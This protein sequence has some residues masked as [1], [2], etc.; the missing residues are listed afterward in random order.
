MF[1]QNEETKQDYK[2]IEKSVDKLCLQQS[3]L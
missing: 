3:S 2:E 1:R